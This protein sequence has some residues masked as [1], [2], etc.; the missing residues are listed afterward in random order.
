MINVEVQFDDTTLPTVTGAN[1][2]NVTV[3]FPQISASTSNKVAK[4][5]SF[6]TVTGQN[7]Y[8]DSD[9]PDL[10]LLVGKTISVEIAVVNLDGSSLISGTSVL[11]SWDDVDFVF[12][13]G[14]TI[15]GGERVLIL[16]Y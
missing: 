4:I 6:N 1:E 16:Y 2:L 5:I 7:S 8:D 9:V 14:I 10:V 11:V 12:N 15:G 13:S 3:T